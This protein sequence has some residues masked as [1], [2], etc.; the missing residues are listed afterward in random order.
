MRLGTLA[1]LY[2]F[3]AGVTAAL[4]LWLMGQVTHLVWPGSDA[5]W[6]VFLVV[7]G[8]GGLI[9]LLRHRHEGHQ[10]DKSLAAQLAGMRNARADRRRS[11]L[12]MAAMA[13]VAVAFG[14]AVGP[15]A[16]ILAVVSELSVLIGL[17][18]A[19]DQAEAR[20]LTEAGAAGALGGLYGSPPA[21][22][23]V[24]Q[25]H[26]EAPRWQLYL[27]G[28]TGLAGFL[29]TAGRF[30]PE[31][32]F[33]IHLPALQPDADGSDMLW[34]LLPAVLAAGAG[35]C[36]VLLLPAIQ[37]ALARCGGVVAQTLVGSALFAALAAAWPIL[38]FSGHHELEAM[39]A[40]GRE[41]GPLMLMAV[42]LLK[43]LAL[44]ICLASGWKGGAA[45]PLLFV[46]AAA[47]A[48]A[49]W[50]LPDA[51]VTV[52]LVSGMTAAL[53]AGMGKPLA[54]V[55]IAALILG[56]SAVGPLCIG[57]AVGWGA[58]RLVPKAELH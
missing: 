5:R 10:E 19:R 23:V 15:E 24:A 36:F 21:G 7:L 30:L 31:N 14:G 6:V 22:A 11:A 28:I 35:L 3:V 13:I 46:G 42:A 54:A 44:A 45:F 18:L 39:L 43:A 34:A 38:R 57:A 2:G 25:E 17:R 47:G 4:V 49:A 26:P 16:G 12:R 8:G 58:S 33:R 48:S 51:P 53:T 41:S 1:A 9:A 20:L 56:T 55:L 29:L 40:L 32:A 37:R 52:L 27:A 50:L